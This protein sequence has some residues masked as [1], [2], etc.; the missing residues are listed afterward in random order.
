MKT[1]G[2]YGDISITYWRV[3]A[4]LFFNETRWRL[5]GPPRVWRCRPLLAT[6]PIQIKVPGVYYPSYAACYI[7]VALAVA[8][9]LSLVV[10]R[11]RIGM[12]IR[13][14]SLPTGEISLRCTTSSCSHAGVRA[15]A[16]HCGLPG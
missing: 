11:T 9:M 14:G 2:A 5:S 15:R 7:L 6:V 16:Q 12:L 1:K 13:A 8:L 3:R 10:M 4:D